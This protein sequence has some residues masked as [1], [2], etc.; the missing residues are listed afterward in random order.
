MKPFIR[1]ILM[2]ACLV[3]MPSSWASVILSL[4]SNASSVNVG[5]SF[6]V[7]I[8][9]AGLGDLSSPSLGAF[10]IDVSFDNSLFGLDLVSFGDLLNGNAGDPLF[11][12]RFVDDSVSGIVS[13]SETSFLFDFELD[14]LQPA[15]FTLATL[16]FTAL[17]TGSGALD[18]A[19]IDLSD[20][21]G[22]SINDATGAGTTVTVPEPPMLALMSAGLIGIGFGRRRYQRR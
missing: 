18:F 21:L 14:A 16:D 5:D 9:I 1:S 6:S 19:L 2:A 11:S 15:S 17:A 3:V 10:F 8:T 7:D 20:E 22:F 12:D 13:L 4:D